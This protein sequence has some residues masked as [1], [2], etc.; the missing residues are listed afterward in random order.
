[1]T[2][3]RSWSPAADWWAGWTASATG[4]VRRPRAS[5]GGDGGCWH[6]SGSGMEMIKLVSYYLF[7]FLF[8]LL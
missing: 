1:M 5:G 4:T 7:K 6:G 8:Y 2:W 3:W